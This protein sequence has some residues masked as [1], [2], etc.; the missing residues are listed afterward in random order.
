MK[1]DNHLYLNAVE[2]SERGWTEMLIRRFLGTPD[3]WEAVNHWANWTGKRTYFLERILNAED[4]PEFADALSKSF[5][6]RKIY[7]SS[8]L[9][10]AHVTKKRAKDRN[11]VRKW[12]ESLT[13]ED[14]KTK[15][16]LN[17]VVEIIQEARRRGYRTPHKA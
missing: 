11:A 12:R 6:R 10:L 13:D 5:R 1:N 9:E 3:R 8:Q 16:S 2:L 15:E 4:S 14:K 7:P 17:K